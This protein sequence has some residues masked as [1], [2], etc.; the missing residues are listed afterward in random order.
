[1]CNVFLIN[2]LSITASSAKKEFGVSS[3]SMHTLPTLLSIPGQYTESERTYQR[4]ISL[5]RILLVAATRAMQEEDS[6]ASY[7]RTRLLGR[8]R[9]PQPAQ[10]PHPCI[11]S[12]AATT[13]SSWTES[14]SLYGYEKT[15]FLDR[16][17][18][19]LEWGVSCQACRLG[20]RDGDVDI[21]VGTLS[22]LLLDIWN[23][24][25]GARCLR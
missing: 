18:G 4:R 24:F 21:T 1:M 23:T 8:R 16:R 6:N 10:L 7:P 14:I 15:P 19:N 5:V 12:F 25:R 3:K 13:R 9:V 11:I 22:T 17:S 2:L 20:P